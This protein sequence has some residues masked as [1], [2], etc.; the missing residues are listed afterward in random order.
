M[1]A[2]YPHYYDKGEDYTAR[3]YR[4]LGR[5]AQVEYHYA[6]D[7]WDS[8]NEFP[9]EKLVRARKMKRISARRA[10]TIIRS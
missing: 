2:K 6:G 8:S 9:T 4:V 7:N 3:V 1:N 5:G 10:N